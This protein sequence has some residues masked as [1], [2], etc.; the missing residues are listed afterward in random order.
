MLQI[1]ARQRAMY[2]VQ[3]SGNLAF[4]CS[5]CAKFQPRLPTESLPA[6]Q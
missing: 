2:F 6:V 5:N 4:S 3:L 1:E